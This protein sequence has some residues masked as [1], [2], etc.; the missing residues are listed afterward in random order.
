MPPQPPQPPQPGYPARPP[1]PGYGASWPV[2]AQAPYT[3]QPPQA[4]QPPVGQTAPYVA[5][6]GY[7]PPQPQPYPQAQPGYAPPGAPPSPITPAKPRRRRGVFWLAT[8]L[9]L[10]PVLLCATLG[11]ITAYTQPQ[12]LAGVP[13]LGGQVAGTVYGVNPA[14]RAAGKDEMTTVAGAT[15]A[16]GGASAITDAQGHYSLDQLRGGTYTCTV[17]SP[18]YIAVTTTVQLRFDSGYALNFGPAPAQSKSVCKVVAGGQLCGGLTLQ[19]GTI[20]GV[21]LDS[22]TQQPVTSAAVTCWDNSQA[23]QTA[24][25]NPLKLTAVVA[26]A[27]GQYTIPNAPA[28]PYLCVAA[29][30]ETPQ[31][32]IS[33]PNATSTLDF[34]VCESSCPGV[35]YHGGDVMHT[36]IGYVIFWTPP[37]YQLDPGGDDA[38]FRALVQQYLSDVGGT[39]FYGL[40]SQ[41]W[42]TNGP[43]RNVATFG[44][45]YVD[46]NPYPH[47]GTVSDPLDDTDIYTEIEHVSEQQ[48]WPFGPGIGYAMVTANG[49]QTCATY[50]QHRSC[51]FPLPDD[52]GFCAYHSSTPYSRTGS[53]QDYMPYML[54]ANVSGCDSLPTYGEAPAPFN[55]PL[56]D[57]IINSMSHEQFEMVSDPTGESW[58][59]D[60]DYSEIG[61][62]CETTFGAPAADGSDVQLGHGHGYALQEEWS[63]ATGSCAYG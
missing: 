12:T 10:I 61:D 52:G 35:V 1:A 11:A 32:V 59:D 39:P 26:S 41:Y 18:Q 19:R 14:A 42:D 2:P 53:T 60:S 44:G 54:V 15:V 58:Y 6:P 30:S 3:P 47:A 55:A 34:S 57:A 43:V 22:S 7:A 8:G 28:G 13:L 37:G 5:A 40:L 62:K 20:S 56:A 17:T 49:V 9:F 36:F 46:T 23:A 48:H 21:V 45:A 24:A 50:E 33:R 63:A 29:Q 16:C 38:G 31:A 4:P 27:T 51:S 25:T